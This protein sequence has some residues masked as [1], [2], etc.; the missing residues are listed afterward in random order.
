MIKKYTNVAEKIGYYIKRMKLELY[1]MPYT[2]YSRCN[3]DLS[4]KGETVKL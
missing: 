4:V 1:T 2:K 3:T